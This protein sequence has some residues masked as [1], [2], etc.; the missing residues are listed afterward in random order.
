MT[1]AVS[2]LYRV[3]RRRVDKG[4]AL[5]A[6]LSDYPRVAKEDRAELIRLFSCSARDETENVT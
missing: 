1:A 2:L 3:V 6:I 4:E 5:D